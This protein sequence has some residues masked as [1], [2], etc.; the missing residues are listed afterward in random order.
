MADV[1]ADLA[2]V[3]P[4]VLE[5]L[6]GEGRGQGV[7]AKDEHWIRRCQPLALVADTALLA[8]PNEFAKGVLEGRLAPVVS[9][10]LS[11]ECGRPI[12]IAITVDDSA[13]EPG[14]APSPAPSQQ[15]YD[16]PHR[17]DEPELSQSGQD[18]DQRDPRDQRE[19]DQREQ[20]ES[21]RRRDDVPGRGEHPGSHGSHSDQLPT[22]RPAYPDYQRPEPGA[23]PRPTQDDYGWQ[24][25][26]L[27]FP[28]R[29]PYA[30]P[31][32]QHDY[33]SAPQDR[34]QYEQDRGQYEQERPSYEQERSQYEQDRSPYE[35]QGRPERRERPDG[36]HGG[37]SGHTGHGGPVG[38]GV[39]GGGPGSAS[40]P[41]SS[42]AP[43]P[44][45]A[46]PAPATGP[47]EPTAR[48]NP[49]YLFDTFVI[50]ASN[51]FAHAAAVAVAEAPAKAYNPL[52]IYGESGLGKTHLLHAIGH[53]ARS[54]YPGTRV[55]YVSSEEFTNEFINSIR[56]GKG[57]SFRKRYREMD[58]LLVDDIQF[59]ADKESTQ[60]EFFHTFNTLH[61]ANKQIVL[62][63]DRPPKQLVTLEDRLRNRFEWGLIT[64]V[65][66]PELETRIAILRKKAVQEQLNAPPEVLE[67]IASRISR[68]IRELEGALIRVTAFASLNRQPVDLGLTEIVLKDLI[69][70]GEDAAPEITAP[71]IMAATADYFGL[72]VDDLCGSSRSRVLVTAR[73][74][75][76]YLCRELTDLSLPKIGA[77]FGGR[78]HTT[79]MHADR[80]I[81]ALMAERRSIYNQVTELTNRIKNG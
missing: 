19:R 35:Q 5:Q 26:R 20:Y 63:S 48:L 16:E 36:G 51:R 24:Q 40:L 72:T 46:Q 11:R 67:F 47:G 57:D 2:A 42:G 64:D 28:E 38:R 29:D 25:P 71:A 52:F 17:Y 3:W 55:R 66:P 70:G 68:N 81:R 54:L 75:A 7:E 61:N 69:P 22:A 49:K 32:S 44:L 62:S 12:R 14:P 74:I 58:I 77:Q 76:M 80:K 43:G 8:V 6:L 45:A 37:H 13:N 65:Q 60:E 53:Y 50:G 73:Q 59:L 18:R 15:R 78:D 9:E 56:D 33:R 27:G 21:Y 79:V 41:A 1:P 23:W 34:S 4:R 30:S 39:H 10:T 31:S